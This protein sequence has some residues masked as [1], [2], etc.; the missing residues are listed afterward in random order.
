MYLRYMSLSQMS[1]ENKVDQEWNGSER[2]AAGFDPDWHRH[3]EKLIEDNKEN[4]E[5]IKKIVTMV[6]DIKVVQAEMRMELKTVVNKSAFTTSS[7]VSTVIGLVS[8][9]ATYL[10]GAR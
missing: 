1:K 4:K 8:V 5:E 3:K 7:I 10:L 2:R 9:L 6:S